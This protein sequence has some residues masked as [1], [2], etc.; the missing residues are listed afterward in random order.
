MKKLILSAV[1]LLGTFAINAQTANDM[2][3]LLKSDVK[4][5]RKA[6]ITESMAFT[7]AESKVFWPIYTEFEIEM[8][9]LASKRIQNIKD[10]A[11][12]Y[13]KM[14]DEKAN[15][16]MESAFDFRSERVDLNESYYK[17]F[18]KVLTPARAAKYMQI[19][20]QIQL[21]IDLSIASELPLVKTPVSDAVK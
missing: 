6:I 2:I 20:D 3:E 5:N 14:T 19:E 18:A 4:T 11:A 1:F 17:K 15:Q 13:D 10:Y 9:K 12:N 16:L 7:E 8:E 21:L